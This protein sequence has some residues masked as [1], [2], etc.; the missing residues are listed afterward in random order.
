M[1]LDP[2]QDKVHALI[3]L[4]YEAAGDPGVWPVFLTEFRDCI[5]ASSVGLVVLDAASGI[6]QINESVNVDPHY[7]KSFNQHYGAINPWTGPEK[8]HLWTPGRVLEGRELISD[9]EMLKTEFYNGFF[10]PQGW[11]TTIGTAFSISERGGSYLTAPRKREVEP[12]EGRLLFSTLVPHLQT[13]MRLHK[14]IAKLEASVAALVDSL[15]L[16]A[17]GVIIVDSQAK[18]LVMN[19]SAE[20]LLA[21]DNGLKQVSLGITAVKPSE[22]KALHASI[23]SA[24][25]AREGGL[26]A[27]RPVSISRGEN[28]RPLQIL[29]APIPPQVSGTNRQAAAVLFLSDP[30]RA[31]EPNLAQLQ[32]A[33]S[34]TKS[35]ARVA[36][37]LTLGKTIEQIAGEF[38]VSPMTVRSHLNR[39]FDKTDTG[40]QTDLVRLLLSTWSNLRSPD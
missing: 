11:F 24:L 10:K 26:G 16:L 32:T 9:R 33:F 4:I 7:Q 25:K 38:G 31:Y 12:D 1:S 34:L 22:A 37:A 36:S 21:G 20:N 2:N 15:D 30:E 6:S 13:A 8:V 17:T 18:V 39:V 23:C 28:R 29:V 19:G 40:R 3:R 5:R 35:E 14:Q 27:P